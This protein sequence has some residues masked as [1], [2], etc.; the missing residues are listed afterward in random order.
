MVWQ[1]LTDIHYIMGLASVQKKKDM[2]TKQR[3]VLNVF[4]FRSGHTGSSEAIMM[5]GK[6][7]EVFINQDP[8]RTKILAG[9]KLRLEVTRTCQHNTSSHLRT[10]R[11]RLGEIKRQHQM[12]P[13]FNNGES[14]MDRALNVIMTGFDERLRL[15]KYHE[16]EKLKL[17]GPC[18]E[19][20]QEEV[21]TDAH[22]VS[23]ID[24]C[25]NT[26]TELPVGFLK[27]GQ[28]P[29]DIDANGI[30]C[31]FCPF[32]RFQKNTLATSRNTFSVRTFGDI[33]YDGEDF[34]CRYKDIL[35]HAICVKSTDSE[36]Y[37]HYVGYDHAF[38]EWLSRQNRR[39]QPLYTKKY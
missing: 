23:F 5:T 3:G 27:H 25:P 29:G 2:K 32:T 39:L 19:N 13:I 28:V 4:W 18:L 1:I 20:I 31:M 38:D 30:Y 36:V 37:V 35:Y 11:Q 21:G 12:K 26:L 14:S 7:Q 16:E 33:L 6:T 22:T 24:L 15:I 17:S 9:N 10:R 8:I 34:L